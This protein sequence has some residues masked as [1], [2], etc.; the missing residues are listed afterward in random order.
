VGYGAKWE[1]FRAIY[2]RYHKANRKLK[3]AILNEFCLNAGYH[4]NQKDSMQKAATSREVQLTRWFTASVFT[5]R[6][7]EVLALCAVRSGL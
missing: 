4:R 6:R 2:E 5:A 3:Q 1:Y 7:P